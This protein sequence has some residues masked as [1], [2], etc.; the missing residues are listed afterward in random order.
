[1]KTIAELLH[2]KPHAE[3]F[4]LS[5]E[6][7]VFDAVTHMVEKNIGAVLVVDK[8]EIHGI[9]TERD[10]LRFVTAKD[11]STRE[12]PISDLM[13]RKVI[14]VTPDVTLDEVM[15]IMTQNRIRHIPVLSEGRLMGIVSIGDVVKQI[16]RNQEVKIRTLE[17]F[18]SDDYPGPQT[19]EAHS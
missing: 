1:M 17:T 7:S 12:T 16:S 3:V 4:H 5:S 6:T 19:K 15:A 9:M 13:T 8:N 18:I 10:Y 14:F 11:R 2:A